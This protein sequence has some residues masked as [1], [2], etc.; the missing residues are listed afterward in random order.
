MAPKTVLLMRHAEKTEDPT[1]PHL[2]EAGFERARKLAEWA[3]KQFDPLHFIVATKN[4]VHSFRPIETVTPLSTS[5]GL[6]IDS[7]LEDQDYPVL[8]DKLLNEPRC[9]GAVVL[10]CWHHGHLPSLASDLR[11][12]TGGFPDPWDRSV[13]DAVW[14]L[15]YGSDDRPKIA[16]MKMPF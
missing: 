5:L 4:S 16:L 3:P 15:D 6:Q 2:S 7:T 12:S 1:N 14:Q 13:F 8:A 9:R 11:A 10:V